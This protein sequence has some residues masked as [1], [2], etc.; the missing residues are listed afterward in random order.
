MLIENLS[1]WPANFT[2]AF[3]KSGHEQIVLATKATFELPQEPGGPCLP[4]ARPLPLIDSDVFGADPATDAT[5]FENDFPA[6]KPR[7]DVLCHGAA[8][9]P[10]GRPVTEI[11]VGI[12]LGAWSK[13][14]TVHGPRIWLRGAAGF[15][16]SDKRAFVSLPLS[17]DTAFGGTDTDPADPSRTATFE[18][19][20]SGIGFY[21]HRADREGAP[22]AQTAEF[23]QDAT[24][25][26]GSYRPMALGPVGRHWLPRRRHAGTYDEAWTDHRMPFLPEDFNESYFQAAAED[27]QIA[28]PGGGEP[29]ELVNL[30]PRGRI[31][32]RLP[33]LQIVVVFERK[34]GRI[35]QRIAN[36]DTIQ[37]LPED[38]RLTLTFR[39]RIT[40][41]RDMFE[42]ARA[43]VS[44]REPAEAPHG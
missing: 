30:S 7:C 24:D 3:A 8:H 40:A 12:R 34:S 6:H 4:A 9:A 44:V 19:N 22:I 11:G 10:D 33:G 35:T 38:H 31:K 36:L 21:P 42:F 1:P 20:P 39:T 23:G 14:F 43:I 15:R 29:I 18:T 37:F 17:Y 5:I 2:M 16:P 27:Q 28:Y 13:K 32:T 41:E 26:T 25:I